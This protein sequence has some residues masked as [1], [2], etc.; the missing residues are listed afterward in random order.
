MTLRATFDRFKGPAA[1]GLGGAMLAATLGL[2]IA[3]IG[4]S[5]K[6]GD[7]LDAIEGD[8]AEIGATLTGMGETVGQIE[9][10]LRDMGADLDS[11][12]GT[13]GKIEAKLGAAEN[14]QLEILNR[15]RQGAPAESAP[16]P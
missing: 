4:L 2:G 13:L 9:A 11:I 12:N 3:A 1:I 16:R 10:G 7:S 5:Y 15:L 14:M 8:T 6:I